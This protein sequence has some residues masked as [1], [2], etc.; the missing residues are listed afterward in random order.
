MIRFAA[1][2]ICL[3][4]SLVL[5]KHYLE[6]DDR[7]IPVEC[8]PLQQ[9]IEAVSF[10]NGIL[11][12][13][14]QGKIQSPPLLLAEIRQLQQIHPASSAF[15]ILEL[16]TCLLQNKTHPAAVFLIEG[17]NLFAPEFSRSKG[18]NN[19]SIRQL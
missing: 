1:H 6:L 19:I 10:Y 17:L 14:E 11:F 13:A 18:G 4:S 9:E 16:S 7:N 15:E 3:S 2:Y 5:K 8:R 12:L